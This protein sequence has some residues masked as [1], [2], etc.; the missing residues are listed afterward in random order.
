M[1][2]GLFQDREV[3]AWL[4]PRRN[5]HL[6]RSGLCEGALLATDARSAMSDK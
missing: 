4:G 5:P 6:E 2:A 1:V 3:A